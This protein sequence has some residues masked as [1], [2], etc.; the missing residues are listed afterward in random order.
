MEGTIGEIR[1]FAANFAPKNWAYCQGQLV[2]I[3]SNTAL[4]SILGTTYGGNGTTTFLLPNLQ[5]R[6]AVGAGNAPGLTPRSLGDIGG[7]GAVTLLQTELPAHTHSLTGTPTLSLNNTRGTTG[8]VAAGLSMANAVLSSNDKDVSSYV[9]A[10]PNITLEANTVKMTISMNPGG[11]Y[12]GNLG[13]NN[14]QPY[15][16]MGYIICQSGA[17]PARG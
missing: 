14:M 15:L 13:H 17:F 5:S 8:T 1:L 6:V 7:L 12:G 10:T 4:F 2:G 11:N 3:A 9:A 16:G